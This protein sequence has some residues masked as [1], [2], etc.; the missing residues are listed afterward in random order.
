MTDY[1][2]F[3]RHFKFYITNT[4]CCASIFTCVMKMIS[5]FLIILIVSKLFL[6]FFF[7]KYS[8]L[9]RL[10]VILILLLLTVT[11]VSLQN[12][13]YFLRVLLKKYKAFSYNLFHD[14]KYPCFLYDQI[15]KLLT[16]N[17]YK[18]A[19]TYFFC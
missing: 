17:I 15:H 3:I 1:R 14:I 2:A 6:G 7:C 11:F 12:Q 13:L 5:V 18:C 16:L 19:L 8:M 4:M 9:L 10:D